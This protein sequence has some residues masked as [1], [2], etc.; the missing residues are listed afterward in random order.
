MSLADGIAW[1]NEVKLTAQPYPGLARCFSHD[2]LFDAEKG[3]PLCNQS[4]KHAK[5]LAEKDA[6]ILSLQGTID[7]LNNQIDTYRR[8][9]RIS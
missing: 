2:Q 5:E 3:C 1:E 6:M 8:E 9:L 7:S 4:M